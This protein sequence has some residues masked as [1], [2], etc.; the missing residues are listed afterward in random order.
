VSIGLRRFHGYL[1]ACY[2][3][4]TASVLSPSASIISWNDA[5]MFCSGESYHLLASCLR[6]CTFLCLGVKPRSIS[7]ASF[8]LPLT[9]MALKVA[10]TL[11]QRYAKCRAASNVF[12]RPCLNM[13][14]YRYSM[15]TT[16]KVMYSVR[17][18]F[19]VPK[20]MGSVTTPTGLIFFPPKP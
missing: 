13:T 2:L 11:R 17:G 5:G 14:L 6:K 15:S 7:Q 8:W 10:G 20:K 9:V 19:G 3:G 16:S 18:F 12:C 1:L 4:S